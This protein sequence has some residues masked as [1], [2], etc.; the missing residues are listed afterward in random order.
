MSLVPAPRRRACMN[1]AT[2]AGTKNTDLLDLVVAQCYSVVK[3]RPGCL[4]S[5]PPERRVIMTD[6]L[7][8]RCRNPLIPPPSPERVGGADR[9]RTGDPLL[10]KQVL[11]QLS[12][13]PT[14]IRFMVGLGRVELPT[15]SLSGMRSSQL[16]YRP[17][18]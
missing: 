8:T 5:L 2:P 6:S 4:S 9:D 16:S 3:Q 15:S 7:L 12:Y 10:A 13:S 18:S 17:S 14:W 11:S 1:A